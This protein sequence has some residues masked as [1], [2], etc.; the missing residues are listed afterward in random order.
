MNLIDDATALIADGALMDVEGFKAL[1]ALY[2]QAEG[3]EQQQVGQC[4]EGFIAGIGDRAVLGSR[5]K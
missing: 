5:I 2:D 3:E 4:L 1:L